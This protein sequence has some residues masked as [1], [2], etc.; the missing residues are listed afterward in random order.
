TEDKDA[1]LSK[2]LRLPAKGRQVVWSPDGKRL[3]VVMIYEP[4]IFGKKERV[5]QL[6]DLAESAPSA[7]SMLKGL[8][9]G[10]VAFSPD[11]KT[12][13]A[14]GTE[15]PRRI[16][17]TLIMEGVLKLWD[18]ETLALKQ[19]LGLGDQAHWSCLAF[20]PDGRLV[21]AG[22]HGKRIVKLWNAETG[23]LER[24]LNTG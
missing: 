10:E 8:W 22:N 7:R 9:I 15:G 19:T 5:V 14:T 24:S 16:G 3:A 20:S 2:V 12:I 6:W 21:A 1:A 17:N 11:G 4:L 23:A 18:T 13:A